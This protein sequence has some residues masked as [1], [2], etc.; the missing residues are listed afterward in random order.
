LK[1]YREEYAL[2]E[3]SLSGQIFEYFYMRVWAGFC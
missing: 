2:K 3:Y 1:N